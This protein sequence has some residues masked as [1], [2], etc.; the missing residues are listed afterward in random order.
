MLTFKSYGLT[1]LWKIWSHKLYDKL[2][3]NKKDL[4]S[5]PYIVLETYFCE[6]KCE[7]P[8]SVLRAF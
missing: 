5:V 1:Y 6:F 4:V 8:V 7:D 2:T 3:R